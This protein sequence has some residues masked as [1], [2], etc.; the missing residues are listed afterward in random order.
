MTEFL[1]ANRPIV[2]AGITTVPGQDQIINNG[3]R[4]TPKEYKI[5]IITKRDEETGY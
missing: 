5:S 4:S 3:F 1:L 2:S